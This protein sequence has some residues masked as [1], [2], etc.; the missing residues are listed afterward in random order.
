MKI[1]VITSIKAPYRTLQLEEICKNGNVN[2]TVYYTKSGK[3]DREWETK[4]SNIFKE[5]YLKRIKFFDKIG[6]FNVGIKNIVKDNDIIV[7]GGYE[8]P[9]YILLSLLCRLYKKKYIIIFDGTTCNRLNEKENSIKWV[10]KN[11][12]I[13][14]SFAIWG[15]GTVSR[16]YFNKIFNYP[17]DKIYNQYLTIN[18]ANVESIGEN[19]YN[20]REELRNKYGIGKHEKILHYSGRLIEVKNIKSIIEALS[21]VKD[22]NITLFIT[23]D[24]ILRNKLEKLANDLG[25]K[26]IITGFIDNQQELF[27][28]YYLSDVF[29]LASTYEP[30]GLVVNEA[31]AA[32]L[33]VLVSSICGC[34]LDLVKEGKNGYC[35]NPLDID[36]I[37]NKIELLF[38][39]KE[40]KEKGI[41]SREIINEY[42]FE[43]SAKMFFKIL[44]TM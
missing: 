26:L 33:P 35:I 38:N 27:K 40:L 17:N 7:L 19:K 25:V 37:A 11:L 34:S 1:A 44:N 15:N 31:M 14:H 32:G 23:G 21:Q 8:K 36:D 42:T 10:L 28:H 30:W 43:N 22:K 12:V 3:E 9:T 20:I 16:K 4:S 29:I 41:N 13:K 24:G 6:E 5:I 39:D 18:V 2:M